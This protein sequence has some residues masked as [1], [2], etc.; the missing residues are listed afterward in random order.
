MHHS[1]LFNTFV[2][3]RD[4]PSLCGTCRMLPPVF[5][6]EFCS[7]DHEEELLF[8]NGFCCEACAT[9]LLKALECEESM[10]WAE[11]EVALDADEPDKSEVRKRR[12]LWRSL[13]A[14]SN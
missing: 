9:R 14:R 7:Y 8:Q 1:L 11:E 6:Y 4:A 13:L 5:H 3:S 2:L 10:D 12:A